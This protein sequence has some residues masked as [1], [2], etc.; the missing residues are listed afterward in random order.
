MNEISITQ[1]DETKKYFWEYN[2]GLI[3]REESYKNNRLADSYE[4]TIPNKTNA[5]KY[6]YLKRKSS[7]NK[8]EDIFYRNDKGVS[9]NQRDG[10]NIVKIYKNMSANCYGKPRKIETKYPD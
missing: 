5:D 9:V 1:N 8:K 4:Y 3:V 10:G 2:S 6:K 7:F